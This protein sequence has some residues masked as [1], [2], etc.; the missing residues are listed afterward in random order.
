MKIIKQPTKPAVKYNVGDTVIVEEFNFDGRTTMPFY[1][2]ATVIKVNRI[3]MQLE[4]ENGYGFLFDPRERAKIVTREELAERVLK[5][6]E[7][8][9]PYRASLAERA[10]NR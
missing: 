4:D 1:T 10:L 5:R 6:Q 8:G 2:T 3:T 7:A 9:L